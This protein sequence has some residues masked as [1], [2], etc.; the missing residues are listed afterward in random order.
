MIFS[1]PVK[2]END[3][4]FAAKVGVLYTT[5]DTLDELIKIK[6]IAPK[7]KILWRISISEENT[8]KLATTFSNK[9]GDDI[10]DLT[11]TA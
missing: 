6:R 5:A 11:E 10:F 4:E 8:E 9:F 3:V 2:E 7:M 1:N